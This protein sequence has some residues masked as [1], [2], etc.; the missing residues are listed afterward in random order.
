[1]GDDGR[2]MRPPGEFGTLRLTR[3]LSGVKRE[4]VETAARTNARRKLDKTAAGIRT[5]I[6]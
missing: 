2:A 1:M 5:W 4:L 3:G 6:K